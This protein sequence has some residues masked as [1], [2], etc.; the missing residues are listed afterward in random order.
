MSQKKVLSKSEESKMIEAA[1]DTQTKLIIETM[2]KTGMRV[3]ELCNLKI[4][5]VNF[6]DNLILVQ[7]NSEPIE[8]SPK[9]GSE[10]EI[11]LSSML[12]ININQLIG[13]RKKGY[14][15]R[16]QRKEYPQRYEPISIINKINALS[17]SIFGGPLGSHILRRTYASNLLYSGVNI[18]TIQK[19]LGHRH[20]TTT[21]VYLKDIPK[22]DDYDQI[23]KAISY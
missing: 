8:F 11:P 16:S 2:L 12:S 3:S 13:K 14:V 9:Y 7:S 20:L 23:R 5:W 15:F 21:L 6:E 4:E 19:L 18:K 17:K 22:R 10:R 1:P